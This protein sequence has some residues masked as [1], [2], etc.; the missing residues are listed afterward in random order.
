MVTEN[1]K[2]AIIGAAA[3]IITTIIG[4]VLN[5]LL[6]PDTKDVSVVV[7]DRDTDVPVPRADISVADSGGNRVAQ[8]LTTMEGEQKIRTLKMGDYT[9]WARAVNYE[10]DKRVFSLHIDPWEMWLKNIPPLPPSMPLSFAG[11]QSWGL[12][13]HPR[14][15]TVT[16]NG[17]FDVAGLVVEN[18]RSLR[19][20]R[21]VLEFA[22]TT[23]SRF[24]NN[25]LVKLETANGAALKPL[26]GVELIKD[27]YIP[28]L[29]GR[30]AYAIPDDFRGRL[31]MVFFKAELHNLQISAFYE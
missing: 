31:N 18:I 11:W 25:Q 1:M 28:V 7:R 15:N 20:K 4:P 9:V 30:V 21:L 22:G 17:V 26:G 19:G 12:T 6:T 14:H 16:L 2:I 3:L 10:E 23:D 27:G 29:D 13:A 8:A 5:H 24:Y